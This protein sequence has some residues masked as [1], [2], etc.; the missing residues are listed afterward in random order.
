MQP[1]C[2]RDGVPAQRCVPMRA[3]LG[4]VGLCLGHLGGGYKQEKLRFQPKAQVGT[5]P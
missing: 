3:D 5:C 1:L 4:S 2:R